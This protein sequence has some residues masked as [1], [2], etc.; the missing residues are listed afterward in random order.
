MAFFKLKKLP[1]QEDL[2]LPFYTKLFFRK[3]LAL[4][5]IVFRKYRIL[6]RVIRNIFTHNFAVF[7]KATPGIFYT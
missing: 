4:F 5:F 2:K 6:Y 7:L 3:C 1:I